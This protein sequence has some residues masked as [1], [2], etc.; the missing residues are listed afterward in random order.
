MSRD[1][2]S[3]FR[4]LCKASE[5]GFLGEQRR[6]LPLS[7]PR[8]SNSEPPSRVGAC[9]ESCV[10]GFH[11]V[12]CGFDLPFTM[13]CA[14]PANN[15][16]CVQ[17]QYW[18]ARTGAWPVRKFENSESSAPETHRPKNPATTGGYLNILQ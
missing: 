5:S 11:S 8:I 18:T 9:F 3:V 1:G 7:F 4:K 15:W 10:A 6:L 14:F 17:V 13:G 12:H 16:S 2:W